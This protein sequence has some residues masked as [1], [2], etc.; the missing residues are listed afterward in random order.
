MYLR[1]YLFA[2][3]L[4]VSIVGSAFSQDLKPKD[5]LGWQDT[6]W[7]MTDQELLAL[8]LPFE[9]SPKRNHLLKPGGEERYAYSVR[10]LPNYE[11]AGGKF[12]VE[13]FMDI[14]TDRL[15]S[16]YFSPSE[17][18]DNVQIINLFFERLDAS[19]TQKYGPPSYKNDASVGGALKRTRQWA[20]P[21]S[22]IELNFQAATYY[23][24]LGLEYK[25]SK[26]SDANKL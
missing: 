24:A 9:T 3:L 15:V 6:R 14:K 8:P 22:L 7:G 11:L 10:Y 16:V 26:G 19:L 5:L 2:L 1:R 4:L 13:F 17:H 20:F 12:K 25:P 21:T 18:A 23:N